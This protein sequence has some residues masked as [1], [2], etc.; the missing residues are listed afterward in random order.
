MMALQKKR[1]LVQLAAVARANG[2][3]GES[4]VQFL[5]CLGKEQLALSDFDIAD[6]IYRA[7]TDEVP[8]AN[9]TPNQR[10]RDIVAIVDLVVGQRAKTAQKKK[11]LEML[12][13]EAAEAKS[14]VEHAIRQLDEKRA[15]LAV[16]AKLAAADGRVGKREHLFMRKTCE[17]WGLSADVLEDEISRSQS[18]DLSIP[19]TEEGRRL[20]LETLVRLAAV[21]GVIDA[22]ERD[23]L[24]E[25]GRRC[26]LSE[27]EIDT[28]IQLKIV[29]REAAILKKR[30]R[31]SGR[32]TRRGDPG[33]S[34]RRLK[35]TSKAPASGVGHRAPLFLRNS[36]SSRIRRTS[37]RTCWP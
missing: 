3:L 34:S 20:L 26:G 17:R 24:H 7:E 31:N 12:A 25:F 11:L 22:G 32:G 33:L 21:D 9:V 2:A 19:E 35:S 5:K 29:S 28:H 27:V 13:A 10:Q 6:A 30:L 15:D 4:I 18:S 14:A 37:C 36:S 23:L 8:F 1:L 16:L